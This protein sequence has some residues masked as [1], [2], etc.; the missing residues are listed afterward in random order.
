MKDYTAYRTQQ[1]ICGRLKNCIAMRCIN[2]G[3]GLN[4]KRNRSTPDKNKLGGFGKH[5]S[6]GLEK[7][8]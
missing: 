4:G 1:G 5:R 2:I 6:W 8:D 3:T 7:S